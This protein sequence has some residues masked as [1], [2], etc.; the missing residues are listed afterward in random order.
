MQDKIFG[1]K[2]EDFF[3]RGINIPAFVSNAVMF[4]KTSESVYKNNDLFTK[5]VKSE[6]VESLK[7]LVEA[8]NAIPRTEDSYVVASLLKTFFLEIPK[9]LILAE[10]QEKLVEAFGLKFL[11]KLFSVL[12]FEKRPKKNKK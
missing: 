7:Q 5:D 11:F 2:L 8:G 1:V 10:I 9:P 4:L 3:D 6:S 12:F